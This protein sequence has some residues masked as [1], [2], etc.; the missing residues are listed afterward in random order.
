VIAVTGGKG[1]VG[2]TSVCINLA[3]SLMREGHRVMLLDA[4]FGLANVDVMLGVRPTL[5]LSHVMSGAASLEDVVVECPSGL[6]IIPSASGMKDMAE[7]SSAAHANLIHAFG[8]LGH[9]I[10]VLLVDTAAGISSGVTM[11]AQAAQEVM[12]VVCDEPASITDAY[13]LIKVL[14]KE[15]GK[16]RFRI[17]A[18]M[19]RSASEGRELYL[20]L[21][22]LAE[23]FLD[24]VLT[25]AGA[26]PF[27]ENVRVSLQKQ[28][29]IVQGFPRSKASLAFKK[30]AEAADKWPRPHE[31]Q[32]QLEF[33][34]EQ[35]LRSETQQ[36][37]APC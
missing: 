1:G 11:L 3:H 15:H 5:N 37:S 34:L 22:R 17:L 21:V 36:G 13:A 32:G 25:Y 10:D 9:D 14:H 33:F 24:V 12:V 28:R 23:R 20:K 35:W 2:K 6:R 8:D 4:D 18:N 29:P 31:V 27:D 7:L 16:S 26:I 30:L 19:T